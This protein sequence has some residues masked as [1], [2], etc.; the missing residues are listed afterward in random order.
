MIISAAATCLA[1]NM[2]FEA[3]NEPQFGQLMVAEVTLNRVKSSRFPDTI[4]DVVWQK[5]QFSWTH[6]GIH[7]D[8]TRMSYLDQKAWEQISQAAVLILSESGERVVPQ[9]GATH[10]HAEYVKPYWVRHMD[11]LGKLGKHLFYKH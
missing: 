9:T 4:C 5:K 11:Y 7:D 3:R 6:D 10:Y 8:P 1:L 2:F